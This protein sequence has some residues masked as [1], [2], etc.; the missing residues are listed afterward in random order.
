MLK[1]ALVA[2]AFIG[3][4]SALFGQTKQLAVGDEL[5]SVEMDLGFPPSK[6]N[7]KEHVAGKSV[8]LMGLPG[9][10]TPT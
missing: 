10:F 5:P 2:L 1:R 6:V 8:I 9:A 7:V 4:A 3:S